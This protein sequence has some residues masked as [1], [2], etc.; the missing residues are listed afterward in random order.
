MK[1]LLTALAKFQAECPA[2]EKGKNNPFFK[3]KYASLDAIQYVIQPF[4][5]KHGLVVTQCNVTTENGLFVETRVYHA[6]SEDRCISSVF[7]IIIQKNTAQDY[8]SAVSYAKRYSLTGVLNVRVVDESDD[9]GNTASVQ[10]AQV[11]KKAAP[12]VKKVDV[13]LPQLIEGTDIFFVVQK[14]MQE[15]QTTIERLKTKY[16]LSKDVEAKLTAK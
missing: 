14:A 12:I 3:S 16:I 8:G 6:D 13:K 15:G 4:L 7:P 2:V 10:S 5:S 11:E 9:D 1:S